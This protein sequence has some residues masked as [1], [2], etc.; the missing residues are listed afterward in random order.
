MN[1]LN[2]NL[3]FLEIK[4]EDSIAIADFKGK[5]KNLSH[6]IRLRKKLFG[7]KGVLSIER[8]PASDTNISV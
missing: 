8:S 1:S 7:V 4:V 6:Y 3:T 5:V 2:I